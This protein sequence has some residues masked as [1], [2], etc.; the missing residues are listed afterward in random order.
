MWD[1]PKST[2][3]QRKSVHALYRLSIRLQNQ[4]LFYPTDLNPPH[5]PYPIIIMPSFRPLEEENTILGKQSYRNDQF[6]SSCLPS[7][8][9]F[10]SQTVDMTKE[11]NIDMESFYRIVQIEKKRHVKR[12]KEK[13]FYGCT[14]NIPSRLRVRSHPD[15]LAES[16]SSTTN[17]SSD[18]QT[19]DLNNNDG[20][21]MKTLHENSFS[22][23]HHE[24]TRSFFITSIS[25]EQR[26]RDHHA[27]RKLQKIGV[28]TES[29]KYI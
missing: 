27:Y 18:H 1:I 28:L 9:S 3:L 16:M 5:H 20:P 2:C 26:S 23:H 15:F 14:V 7:S 13:T 8:F 17:S 24:R 19:L 6:F 4:D 29:G 21:N 25:N 22:S 10:S 12:R 11:I